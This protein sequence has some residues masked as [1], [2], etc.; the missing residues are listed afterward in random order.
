MD[1]D[2]DDT[3]SDTSAEEESRNT[4]AL[5]S[6]AY[7]IEMFEHSMQGNIIAVMGT[8]MF[9]PRQFQKIFMVRSGSLL[10]F[11]LPVLSLDDSFLS[12]Y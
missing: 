6:R 12:F 11:C 9:S 2:S 10:S 3:W 8:G 5:Q 7:Q 1:L 4:P